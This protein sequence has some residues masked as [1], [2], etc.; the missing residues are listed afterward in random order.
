MVRSHHMKPHMYKY[1]YN[2]STMGCKDKATVLYMY[3]S[4]WVYVVHGILRPG[5]NKAKRDLPK[6][7]ELRQGAKLQIFTN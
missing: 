7:V 5:G 3:N 6:V 4:A 2:Y 1:V